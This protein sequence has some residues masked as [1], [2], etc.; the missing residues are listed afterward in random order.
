MNLFRF[1]LSITNA[2]S[3]LDVAFFFTKNSQN[4]EGVVASE[5]LS[6]LYFKI[7]HNVNTNLPFKNVPLQPF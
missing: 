1:N 3:D 5:K 2:T 6:M 4:T 7:L